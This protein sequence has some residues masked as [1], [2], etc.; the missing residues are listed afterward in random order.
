[1]A[2]RDACVYAD[3]AALQP[4]EVPPATPDLDVGLDLGP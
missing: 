2:D 3:L 1:L 4:A